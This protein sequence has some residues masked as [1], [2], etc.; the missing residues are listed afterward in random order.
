[1][2]GLSG[3]ITPS[4]DEMV[5]VAERNGN[6]RGMSMP[7]LIGGATTSRVHTALRIDAGLCNGP[8]DSCA[9]RQPRGGR[10][11]DSCMSDTQRRRVRRERDGDRVRGEIRDR[12]RQ[13]GA[14]RTR[15]TLAEARANAFPADMPRKSRPRRALPGPHIFPDWPISRT[16]AMRHR[17][18]AVLPRVGTRGQLPRD[19]RRRRGRRDLREG[20]SRMRRRCST[21]IIAEKWLTARK[22]VTGVLA[23]PPRG[24]RRAPG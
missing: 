10:G 12:P 2:I 20:C 15:C 6:A 21:C 11:L 3:L 5:T 8:V 16:C 7:L 22:A 4:L 24:R 19:P 14:V 9:R 17:L 23:V 13:Q 18:D 1:M